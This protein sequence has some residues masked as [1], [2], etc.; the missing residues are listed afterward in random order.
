VLSIFKKLDNPELQAISAGETIKFSIYQQGANYLASGW[1]DS[2]SWGAWSAGHESRLRMK[3]S[4]E[5]PNKII[6]SVRAL[7][8]STLPKQILQIWANDKFIKTVELSQ[9][10]GN[11]IELNVPFESENLDLKFKLPNAARP[12]DLGINEDVRQIAIGL[13]SAQFK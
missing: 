6:F 13:E 8:N 3:F 1:Q 4:A 9:P 5:R 2:E 12:I 11:K 10:F 7:V